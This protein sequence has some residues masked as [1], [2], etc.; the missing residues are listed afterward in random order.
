MVDHILSQED[1]ECQALV[2]L[3]NEANE[4]AEIIKPEDQEESMLEFGSE[5]EDYDRLFMDVA[6]QQK[7]QAQVPSSQDRD[8]SMLGSQEMDVSLD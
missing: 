5:A 7:E 3:M 6:F 8:C 4:A 1:E 2:C